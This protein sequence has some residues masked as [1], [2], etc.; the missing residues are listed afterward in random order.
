M[1]NALAY[2]PFVHP[3]AAFHDWW[4]LLLVP[5]ALGISMVYK[6][7]R[8]SSLHGYLRHVLVMTAQ[9]VL[10]MIALAIVLTILVQWV[11]PRLPAE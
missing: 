8:M 1:I 5:L 7:L 9:I 10:A 2:I 3:I 4:Y 6:A 11:I